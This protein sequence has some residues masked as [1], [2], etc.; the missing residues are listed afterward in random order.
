M[1]QVSFAALAYGAKL[2]GKLSV[3]NGM[4][5]FLEETVFSCSHGLSHAAGRR[6]T[7]NRKSKKKASEDAFFNP[8]NR[9]CNACAMA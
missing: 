8:L 6:E 5:D 3:G 4:G 2:P 7:V 9:S 1:K